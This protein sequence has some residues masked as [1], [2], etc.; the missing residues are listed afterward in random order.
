[1]ILFNASNLA[2]W[3]LYCSEF[4]NGECNENSNRLIGTSSQN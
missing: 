3:P 2:K 1:M 4:Q